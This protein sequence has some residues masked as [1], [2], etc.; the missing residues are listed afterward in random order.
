MVCGRSRSKRTSSCKVS[1]TTCVIPQGSG[2]DHLTVEFYDISLPRFTK[3]IV[4]FP[5][6]KVVFLCF[7]E[8]FL[9]LLTFGLTVD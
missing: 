5:T 8:D 7:R 3:S 4:A 1:L 6:S 9:I 2:F